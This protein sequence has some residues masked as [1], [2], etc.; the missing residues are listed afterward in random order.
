[1]HKLLATLL[2]SA[3]LACAG[4]TGSSAQD[5][6][7]RP[8][9]LVLPYTAG[10]GGDALTRMLAEKL[11]VILGQQVL[12]E[13]R[14]GAGTLIGTEFVARSEPDGYTLLL[15]FSSLTVNP[16]VFPNAKY[17]ALKDFTTVAQVADVPH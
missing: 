14:P 6:P 15:A 13:N 12:V 4:A 17:D 3:I 1:M 7:S 16:V 5:Y 2:I 8:I 11:R 9:R 10:G